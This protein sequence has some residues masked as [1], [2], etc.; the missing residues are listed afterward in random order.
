MSD[1]TLNWGESEAAARYQ[2][3]DSD[4]DGGDF[5]VAKN[6]DNETVLLQ[7][8]N[9]AEQWVF[10]GDVDLGGNDVT[11]AGVVNGVDGSFDTLEAE[12]V[13]T[14][15]LGIGNH[16]NI[17]GIEVGQVTF[18]NADASGDDD[19]WDDRTA[20]SENDTFGEAFASTPNAIVTGNED[21]GSGTINEGVQT[22]VSISTT[23]IDIRHIQYR[24]QD[25]SD[26]EIAIDYVAVEQ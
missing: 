10:A 26:D 5:I 4:P 12:S 16:D 11:N 21:A 1:R 19:S 18:N 7:F 14:E 13:S 20:V 2:T 24:G 23:G 8:D 22:I 25:R 15:A 17:K 9:T 6:T 3:G